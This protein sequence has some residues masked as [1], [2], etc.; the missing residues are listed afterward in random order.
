[1][2]R[3]ELQIKKEKEKMKHLSFDID[4]HS[5]QGRIFRIEVTENYEGDRYHINVF[6]KDET[7]YDHLDT[8]SGNDEKHFFQILRKIESDKI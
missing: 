5:K 3:F 4:L 6:E 7:S 1:V 2:I 8:I